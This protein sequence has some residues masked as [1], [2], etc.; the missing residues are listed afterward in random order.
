M[1]TLLFMP[2]CPIDK[3]YDLGAVE[4]IPFVRDTAFAGVDEVNLRNL[5]SILATYK[6]LQAESVP[7][8]AVVRYKGRSAIADLSDGEI[9]VAYDLATLAAFAGLAA[10]DFLDP[11]GFYCNADCFAMYVQ[12]FDNADFT[13]LT[14]RRRAGKQI[15]AWPLDRMSMTV[16]VHCHDLQRVTVNENVLS[17]LL[18]YRSL[19]NVNEWSRWQSSISCF[20]QANTDSE[21][22]QIQ[23]EWVLLCGA[24]Q[25]LLGAGSKDKAVATAFDSAIVPSQ[26][27]LVRDATRRLPSW[28]DD[29]KSLR[30]AWMKEFY[31]VRG[32]FAHGKVNTQRPTAWRPHEHVVLAS[33][34]F[35]LV[36]KVLL[37]ELG[38]YELAREDQ[39]QRNAFERFAD[40]P[41]F[42]IP[43]VDQNNGTD[44]HW[45]RVRQQA[46]H[47][48]RV[49]AAVQAVQEIRDGSDDIND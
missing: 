39:V 22:I 14:T 42:L 24:I 44:T 34:A 40:I 13:A 45:Q 6:S 10:R 20:N 15:A 46:L 49:A 33:I 37:S 19:A 27:I 35:P 4:L 30:Y 43:P 38:C 16:P 2:W 31:G 48:L 9:N 23:T 11:I 12:K 7:R 5:N 21:G 1:S 17:A 28:L 32:D 8:L 3:P 26:E 36:A 29:T 41:N 47:A 25:H 18:E